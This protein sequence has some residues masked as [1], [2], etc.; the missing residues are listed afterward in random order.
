MTAALSRT[1]PK[2][3]VCS[4]SFLPL[5]CLSH[6][7]YLY[8]VLFYFTQAQS[9]SREKQSDPRL[10]KEISKLDTL[11]AQKLKLKREEKESIESRDKCKQS[12]EQATVENNK[13]CNERSGDEPSTKKRKSEYHLTETCENNKQPCK[14]NEIDKAV[15]HCDKGLSETTIPVEN[16]VPQ[17]HEST[18]AY[19]E[20]KRVQIV[21][22]P[23]EVGNELRR[24]NSQIIAYE[25]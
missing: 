5:C 21:C 8:W 24:N 3:A 9:P 6:F 1:L 13:H 4:S 2:S 17:K 10:P 7:L 23:L 15:E 22:R 19:T 16:V 14:L 25:V 12:E 20:K 18:E 11:E